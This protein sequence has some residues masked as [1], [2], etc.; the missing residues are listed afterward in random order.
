M[1]KPTQFDDLRGRYQLVF[2]KGSL[3]RW[4]LG[5][6]LNGPCRMFQMCMDD[7]TRIRQNV[8]REILQVCGLLDE[9]KNPQQIVAK[10]A[11]QVEPE[12]MTFRKFIKMKWK[13]RKL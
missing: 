11:S 12:S 3:G 9:T 2:L 5:N 8:G 10:L 7:E 4:V 13:R 1:N 6:I